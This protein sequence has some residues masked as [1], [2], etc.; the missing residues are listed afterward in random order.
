[1]VCGRILL[2]TN[3]SLSLLAGQGAFLFVG[4]GRAIATQYLNDDFDSRRLEAAQS[5]L[6]RLRSS[7]TP[8]SWLRNSLRLLFP[9]P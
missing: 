6:F 3:S 2:R 1:M 7:L 5:A 9:T 8:A 4:F